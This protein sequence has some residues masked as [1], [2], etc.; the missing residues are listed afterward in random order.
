MEKPLLLCIYLSIIH[1][2]L[3]K[4]QV[5][6][7]M[8]RDLIKSHAS[9]KTM[10]PSDCKFSLKNDRLTCTVR[11]MSESIPYNVTSAENTDY[12]S[13]VRVNINYNFRFRVLNA[14]DSVPRREVDGEVWRRCLVLTGVSFKRVRANGEQ[15][16]KVLLP[17]RLFHLAAN[18]AL[19]GA[20][21]EVDAKPGI[22]VGVVTVSVDCSSDIGNERY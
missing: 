7:I 21:S 19:L 12:S 11:L 1:L 17:S 20:D 15:R 18:S 5:I 10:N 4:D 3:G 8:C 9:L 6:D 14:I 22:P 16:N 13:L 2:G